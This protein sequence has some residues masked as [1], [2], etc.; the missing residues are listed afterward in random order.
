MPIQII[1]STDAGA[2]VLNGEPGSLITVLDA[3]TITGFGGQPAIG[4][5]KAFSGV[6]RAAY[7][8]PVG[9]TQHYLQVYDDQV[10]NSRYATAR[11]FESMVDVD[12]GVGQFPTN[13]QEANYYLHKS[14]VSNADPVEWVAYTN[15]NF[16]IFASS[17]PTATRNYGWAFGHINSLIIGDNWNTFI[18]G[19]DSSSIANTGLFQDSDKYISRDDSGLNNSVWQNINAIGIQ[20]VQ[21]GNI[22]SLG[23]YPA[24]VNN[25]L[26]MVPM[27]YTNT[28]SPN[29]LSADNLRAYVPGVYLIQ[30]DWNDVL[31]IELASTNFSDQDGVT[32]D[33]VQW[34]RTSNVGGIAIQTSGEWL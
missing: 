24:T 27:C 29:L 17:R 34:R 2:P 22:N 21:S 26:N 31:P 18:G 16:L 13:A 10:T 30:A 32:Y 9:T 20:P 33:Y 11:G 23:V 4:W 7:R 14:D 1:R 12:T 5:T 8:L 28:D 15:G 19:S 6:N 25:R 3:L